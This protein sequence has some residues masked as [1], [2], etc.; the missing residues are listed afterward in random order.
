M[1][2]TSMARDRASDHTATP[3][4]ILRWAAI[5]E[6]GRFAS[7]PSPKTVTISSHCADTAPSPAVAAAS[8]ETRTFRS[9]VSDRELAGQPLRA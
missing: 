3:A 7:R 5:T 6:G 1:G 2:T 8:S 4:R 9:G